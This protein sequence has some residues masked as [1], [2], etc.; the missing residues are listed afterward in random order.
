MDSDIAALERCVPAGDAIDA[1]ARA[2]DLRGTYANF[3][4]CERAAFETL[5]ARLKDG[6]LEA[7]STNCSIDSTIDT[8]PR[9]PGQV[10]STWDFYSHDGSPAKVPIEFW[11]HFHY[12]GEGARVFDAIAGDFRF[13]YPDAEYSIRDGVAYGVHFDQRGLPPASVP[14]W[15]GPSESS[16]RS[17][18]PP[19]S[20]VP[21]APR[22]RRPANWWPDF[23]EELAAHIHDFGLPET[24]DAM[25]SA[26]QLAMTKRGKIEP[27]RAA[28]QPVVRAL[29]LRIGKA[30]K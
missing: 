12:A 7:W 13:Q 4:V 3:G 19:N 27:S 28:I 14:N 26:V 21:T 1:L 24:Q 17:E 20:I 29:F 8:G 11:M 10:F 18:V 30:I 6:K 15:L 5:L 23:A 2:H 9:T 22:G 16:L 25:I